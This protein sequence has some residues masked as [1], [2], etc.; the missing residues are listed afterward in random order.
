MKELNI[1]NYIAEMPDGDDI[2]IMDFDLDPISNKVVLYIVDFIKPIGQ[3][4]TSEIDKVTNSINKRLNWIKSN[5]EI[6]ENGVTEGEIADLVDDWVSSA[7]PSE[8]EENTYIIEDDQKVTVP[9][10]KDSFKKSLGLDSIAIY[11]DEKFE[12]DIADLYITCSPDYFA[13]HAINISISKAKEIKYR[14]L[15]G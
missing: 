4:S 3:L 11:M 5:Y 14:G 6:I 9:V 10:S 8:G 7:K 15:I 2:E 1:K 12:V 13:G